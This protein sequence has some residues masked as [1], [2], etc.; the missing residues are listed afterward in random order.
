M[1]ISWKKKAGPQP[2]QSKLEKRVAMISTPDLVT[3]AENALFVIGKETTG[4]MRSKDSALLDEA[5]VGAEALTA[6]LNELKR[7]D[8]DF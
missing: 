7:R 8:N 2:Q 1:M 6:I 3:W 4:W 5:L